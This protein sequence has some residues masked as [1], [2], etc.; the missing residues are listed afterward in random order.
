MDGNAEEKHS[1]ASASRP[2]A[3]LPLP[4]AVVFAEHAPRPTDPGP[5]RPPRRG[6]GAVGRGEDDGR[7]P[8]RLRRVGGDPTGSVRPPPARPFSRF[9]FPG[10]ASAARTTP[11]RR[12]DTTVPGSASCPGAGRPGPGRHRLR[13]AAHLHG[14]PGRAG[15]P[16]WRGPAGPSP[17]GPDRGPRGPL[18]PPGPRDRPHRAGPPPGRP[19]P[20]RP[21][22]PPAVARRPAP[23]RGATGGGVLAG[24]RPFPAGAAGPLRLRHGGRPGGRRPRPRGH[25]RRRR[26]STE[27]APRGGAVPRCAPPVAPRLPSV[28][29]KS[30]GRPARPPR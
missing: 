10:R 7:S 3:A 23:T 27:R 21:G 15:G 26:P 6:G 2:V 12:R 24:G 19:E 28:R 29:V 11:L 4:P 18:G 13:G 1:V 30:G 20:A 17:F 16:R 22:R 8:S 9:S 5:T 14:E 25:R